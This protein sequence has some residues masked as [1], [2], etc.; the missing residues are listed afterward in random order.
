VVGLIKTYGMS[1]EEQDQV[2][3]DWRAGVS[4][5]KIGVSLGRPHQHGSC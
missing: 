4:L 2:W 5:S 3:R 1:V